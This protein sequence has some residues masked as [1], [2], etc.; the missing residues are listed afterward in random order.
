MTETKKSF[1]TRL[2]HVAEYSWKFTHPGRI[3]PVSVTCQ[4]DR[5]SYVWVVYV[6]SFRVRSEAGHLLEGVKTLLNEGDRESG[7]S[8]TFHDPLNKSFRK[9]T[10]LENPSDEITANPI[11]SFHETHFQCASGRTSIPMVISQKILH[12]KSIL[13]YPSALEKGSLFAGCLQQ[14]K[15]LSGLSPNPEKSH[16]FTSG[17]P[18][19]V[20][21]ELLNILGYKVGS[22]PVLGSL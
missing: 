3:H 8:E 21:E 12:Q 2:Q 18:A 19:V 22:L 4:L 5:L 13:S 7:S 17:V 6:W 11:V 1:H 10:G 9:A 20:K 14:F 16:L 15:D